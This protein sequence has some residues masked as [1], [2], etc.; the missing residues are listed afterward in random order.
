MPVSCRTA[1]PLPRVINQR[2]TGRAMA[3]AMTRATERL[4]QKRVLVRPAS[5]APGM[6][7]MIAL[8]TISITV[9]LS[10]S[11]ASAIGITAE[12]AR[13]ARSRGMLVSV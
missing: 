9:M 12:S 7:S 3:P 13:P 11:T 8:S 2:L 6:A 1:W 10:V 5:M 4:P